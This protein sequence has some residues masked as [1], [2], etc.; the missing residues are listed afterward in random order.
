MT[1]A[2]PDDRE[3]T[4]PMARIAPRCGSSPSIKT[5]ISGSG[6][7]MKATLVSAAKASPITTPT[8]NPAANSAVIEVPVIQP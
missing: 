7:V 1:A 6:T 5:E 4:R 8:D 2:L 3:G